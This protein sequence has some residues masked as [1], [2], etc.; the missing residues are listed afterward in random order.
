MF[1]Q[2]FQNSKK[3]ENVNIE[4][5]FYFKSV[6][7]TNSLEEALK[8]ISAFDRDFNGG[9]GREY[10]WD[11]VDTAQYDSNREYLMKTL[12]S[13]GREFVKE[14]I[15]TWME[16]DKGYYSQYEYQI[17]TNENDEVTNISLVAVRE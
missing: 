16:H 7:V 12:K 4:N 5:G 14:F 10:L 15:E 17:D 1:L 13:T 2:Q 6:H 9:N 8:E 3:V 11:E